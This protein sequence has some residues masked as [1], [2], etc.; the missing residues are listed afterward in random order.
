MATRFVLPQADV[1]NGIQP[2]DGAQLFF[3]E[4]GTSM[5]KDTWTTSTETV[6]NS[7]PVISDANGVFPDIYING[8]YKV[9]LKD[10]NN[11][12]AG[13]GVAD[14]VSAFS[15]STTSTINPDNVTALIALNPSIGD[16]A[17]TKGYYSEGDRGNGNY[18]AVAKFAE[19]GFGDHSSSNAA[20]SWKLQPVNAIV[21]VLQYGAKFDLVT[22]DTASFQAALDSDA[23]VV[24]MPEGDTV[25][26]ATGL[27]MESDQALIG[28]GRGRTFIRIT[29]DANTIVFNVSLAVGGFNT[30]T[31][32][33]LTLISNGAV[34]GISVLK[35]PQD[36]LGVT[37]E[38]SFYVDDVYVLSGGARYATILDIG[39]HIN[40]GASNIDF[41]GGYLSSVE[42][43]L[44]DREVGISLSGAQGGFGFQVYNFKMS[45]FS[46][47][48]FVGEGIE[49]FYFRDGEATTSWRG[50]HA[51]QIISHPG[52]NVQN[53]HIS[54]NFRPIDII[55]RRNFQIDNVQLYRT[56]G[57]AFDH[58][59]EWK[60][61]TINNCSR[62]NLSNIQIRHP[63]DLKLSSD[64]IGVS[65][66]SG[67]FNLTLTG[68][69]TGY[70]NGLRK[71]LQLTNVTGL[72]ATGMSCDDVETNI[73]EMLG[74]CRRCVIGPVAYADAVTP[75]TP[76]SIDPSSVGITNKVSRESSYIP[77]VNSKV[78]IASTP[79][80]NYFPGI[81]ALYTELVDAEPT[82]DYDYRAT[83][84]NNDALFGDEF[85][86]KVVIPATVHGTIEIRNEDN[87]ISRTFN[88]QG[89][90]W[91]VWI[92]TGALWTVKGS[93]TL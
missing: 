75:V 14:P 77:T 59:E 58:T 48:L 82:T 86:F 16:T 44:Q 69:V 56:T 93:G 18:L 84:R 70:D 68:L 61:L 9:Q 85:S 83:L 13:F 21:N 78:L 7:N 15:D 35:T 55:N 91:I 90:F 8:T 73:I 49:A 5:P 65:I 66:E 22:D 10:K 4:T 32:K 52:G 3:F 47:S 62:V 53:V 81:T 28:Q 57:T 29:P 50:I 39:D 74:S 19:D 54:A 25:I 33:G 42:D 1:G 40:G 88:T 76:V 45:G 11:V 63:D 24:Y 92:F 51:T 87:S 12:L 41:R 34:N 72:N 46:T 71:M 30:F 31:L 80:D 43:S 6:A 38:H 27:T 17:S 23:L 64:R 89:E 26:S 60:G 20:V 79:N 2:E 36:A 37:D 67:S